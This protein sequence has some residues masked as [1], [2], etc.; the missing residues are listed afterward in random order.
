MIASALMVITAQHPVKSALALVVCF[1]GATGLWLLLTAEFLALILILVYV[2]AIMTLFLF[3]VMTINIDYAN[4]KQ[5]FLRYYIPMGL[6]I[7]ALLV[8]LLIYAIGA[9]HAPFMI[10]PQNP[11]TAA[12][13][14]VN[15]LGNVLY[16]QY[17]LP[18]EIAAIILLVA[19]IAA[20]SLTLYDAIHRKQ[21]NIS[22]QIKVNP[23][24]RV[25]LIDIK[26]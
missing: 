10:L 15:Q 14:N 23:K 5:P 3:V 18:F 25:K 2:G 19:M 1:F 17:A 6:L 20:I 13:P 9:T 7:T 26:K 4:L 24:D 11:A 22:D 8:A 16:T 12:M 21:Q